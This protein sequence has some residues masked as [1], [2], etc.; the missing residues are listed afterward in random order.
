MRLLM[1][2]AVVCFTIA[3]LGQINVISGVGVLAWALAGWLAWSIDV[4]LG[5]YLMPVGR[6]TRN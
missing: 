4:A 1:L 2:V 5:G 6:S 3:L